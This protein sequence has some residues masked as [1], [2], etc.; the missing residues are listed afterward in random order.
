VR[1]IDSKGE[2]A[3]VLSTIKALEMAKKSGLDLVE[4]SPNAD[5]PVCKV[6]DFGKYRYEQKK[7]LS[8][9]KKRQK[10]TTDKT[11]KYRPATGSFFE[12]LCSPSIGF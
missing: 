8:D 1:L 12:A 9:Q 5:P 7:Q 6:M 2:Q 3:G 4:V 10:K 11:I